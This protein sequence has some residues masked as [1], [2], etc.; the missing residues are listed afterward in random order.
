MYHSPRG[1]LFRSKSR[2]TGEGGPSDETDRSD[3]FRRGSPDKNT[4]YRLQA[5]SSQGFEY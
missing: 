2:D 5:V 1:P 4:S 3:P